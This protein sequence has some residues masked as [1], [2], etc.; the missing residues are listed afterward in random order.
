[1]KILTL[2]IKRPYLEDILS[3][4]KTKEYRE[5]RPKNADKYIIQNPDAEDEDQWLQ[6][7]KYDAIK[8]LN[9]YATNRPEVVIEITNSEIELSVDEN[10]EEI[11]YEEDGQEYIE[12]Q[13]V[14]TLGKVLSKKNI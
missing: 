1:M 11:T 6:P 10:G 4:T 13:M 2:Q 12:A 14:Y 7:V 9:G 8:F 3:G 5:I